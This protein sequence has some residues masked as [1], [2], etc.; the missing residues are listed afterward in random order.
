MDFKALYEFRFRDIDQNSRDKVWS[1]ISP[2]I[3]SKAGKPSRVL[4]PACGLGEFINFCP[5]PERWAADLG[6]DGS[7]LD[8]SVKFVQGSFLETDLP[9]EYFDLVF[10]SNVLE[11]MDNQLM[12]NRFLTRAYEKLR[13]GGIVIVMGPNFK[14]CANEYFDCADHSVVL[15]HISVEEHLAA[16]H[17]ELIETNSRFLPYS[18]RSRL[19]ATRITTSMY[20][21]SKLA[22]RLLG[23]Q[24]LLIAQRPT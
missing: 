20:L 7:S 3:T 19:P 13:P 2:F 14:F 21:R 16:A 24:F 22:W 12:V 10:L 1:I 9:D 18:F 23:K 8:Q 15:T 11:H 4:D 17:F 6:L 5:A